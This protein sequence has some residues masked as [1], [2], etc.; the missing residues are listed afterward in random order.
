MCTAMSRYCFHCIRQLRRLC[1]NEVRRLDAKGWAQVRQSTPRY[2]KVREGTPDDKIVSIIMNY[3]GATAGRNS[4]A[5]AAILQ[6]THT[7]AMT[8]RAEAFSSE[9]SEPEPECG[10]DPR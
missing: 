8:D 3:Y 1:P 6:K 9:R 10:L 2:A 4:R 7:I 5:K